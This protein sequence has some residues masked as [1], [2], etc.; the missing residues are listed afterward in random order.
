[1]QHISWYDILNATKR[2][3]KNFLFLD[4]YF[5]FLAEICVHSFLFCLFFPDKKSTE[6]GCIAVSIKTMRIKR[7]QCKPMYTLTTSEESARINIASRVC[8]VCTIIYIYFKSFFFPQFL[9]VYF[10]HHNVICVVSVHFTQ[11]SI[12]IST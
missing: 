10:S 8:N 1:M 9:A 4:H 6:N 7:P 2:K 3:E 5:G 12:S 11:N